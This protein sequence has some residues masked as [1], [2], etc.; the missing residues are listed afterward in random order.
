MKSSLKTGFSF[1]LTSGVITTLGL[2][3]GLHSGTHSRT[4]LIGGIVTIAVADALSD[5]LGIHISEE[6]KNNG[7]VSE[8][9][10]STIATF[11]AKFLI[12]MTFVAP[13]LWLPLED[14]MTVSVVWG[15]SLLAVL[16]YFLARAQ[17]IP[18]W[19]VISEHLVIGVSVI[20]STHYLGDWIHSTLS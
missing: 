17:Q 20:A 7:N 19:K 11:V 14:A 18:A 4:V 2:M 8:V 10:E 9:W 12:A 3:M 5:A 15:L 13:V 16:S 1:G 6:S